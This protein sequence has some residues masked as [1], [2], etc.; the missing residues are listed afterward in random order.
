MPKTVRAGE[1]TGSFSYDFDHVYGDAGKTTGSCVAGE[2]LIG[3]KVRYTKRGRMFIALDEYDYMLANGLVGVLQRLE[4]TFRVFLAANS[5]DWSGTTKEIR[6][7]TYAESPD[8]PVQTNA[9]YI[10]AWNAMDNYYRERVFSVSLSENFNIELTD[11]RE[12]QYVLDNGFGFVDAGAGAAV[13]VCTIGSL[14]FTAKSTPP[15]ITEDRSTMTG[16]M[17]D[18][19]TYVHDPGEDF[20]F[21]YT[22][23]QEAGTAMETAVISLI[24]DAAVR[25][26]ST[27]S[28]PGALVIPAD[29]WGDL[30][31]VGVIRV[32]AK[33]VSVGGRSYQTTQDIPF[34]V[35]YREVTPHGIMPEGTV[36]SDTDI[37]LSWDNDIIAEGG[38]VCSRPVFWKVWVTAGEASQGV[39]LRE[40]AVNIDHAILAGIESIS[41]RIESFYTED[42][43]VGTYGDGAF[44]MR[45]WVRQVAEAGNVLVETDAFGTVPP[46]PVVRWESDG[47][48]AVRVR[49]G[50]FESGVIFGTQTVYA[51]PHIFRDGTYPVQISVQGKNG[52]WSPFTSPV[53]A[54]VRNRESLAGCSADI[55]I[56]GGRVMLDISGTGDG[57]WFAVFRDGEFIGQ[58]NFNG[59][60][61]YSDPW[62]NGAAV[63]EVLAIDKN[64]YYTATGEMPITLVLSADVLTVNGE[65][66]ALQYTADAPV[67]YD[68]KV[69]EKV[70]MVHF[71]GRKYPVAFR[72]GN[73]TKS[74]TLSYADPTGEL[75]R[76]ILLAQGLDVFFRDVEGGSIFGVL[77][78]VSVRKNRFGSVVSFTVQETD[79]GG[80]T[81]FRRE[82]V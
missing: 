23:H 49:F 20:R 80:E 39:L 16:G 81:R 41:I 26:T 59:M 18:G 15:E 47:Q 64:G 45:L 10:N 56:Q 46:L 63:Y 73:F 36:E 29:A 11:A 62:V 35:A 50:D 13:I 75:E 57:V 7:R 31:C 21:G 34:R 71:S 44:I 33:T 17:F 2:T 55:R 74:I 42:G 69:A 66:T 24:A 78:N 5:E 8:K 58:A 82:G 65:D 6:I 1:K 77:N 43:V 52:R 4:L 14:T 37:A 60:V 19:G 9:N 3:G 12:I 79:R 72:S 38:T 70:D 32:V 30:P 40:P 67:S 76:V 22:Y 51:V 54:V 61:Q 28:T 68:Y 25:Y 53:Y 27:Q 48:T